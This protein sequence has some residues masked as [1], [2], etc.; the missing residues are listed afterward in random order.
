MPLIIPALAAGLGTVQPAEQEGVAV[1]ALTSAWLNYVQGAS[2]LGVPALRPVLDGLPRQAFQGPL[3]GIALQG[4]AAT[5]LQAAILAFWAA[6]GPL[7]TAI[8]IIPPPTIIVPGTLIPPPGNASLAASILADFVSNTS[9]KLQLQA[10]GAVLARTI[11]LA[12]LGGTIQ[13]QVL[14]AA[15]VITPIL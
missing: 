6:C 3:N 1:S 11:G 2:V 5:R 8:W 14:P 13:T 10:A 12:Q 9:G 4:T 15:P 7:A